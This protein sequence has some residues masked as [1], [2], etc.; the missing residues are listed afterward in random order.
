VGGEYFQPDATYRS[1]EELKTI[2]SKIADLI[3][4]SCAS[5]FFHI[6]LKPA[7]FLYKTNPEAEIQVVMTDFDARMFAN[8]ESE[9]K[10]LINPMQGDLSTVKL[11]FKAQISILSSFCFFQPEWIEVQAK[12]ESGTIAIPGGMKEDLEWY[13]VIPRHYKNP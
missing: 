1:P 4:K 12:I 6:D 13:G 10:H 5:G 9:I 3:D 7:N 2:E 11:L 8:N